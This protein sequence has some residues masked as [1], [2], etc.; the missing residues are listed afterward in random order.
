MHLDDKCII[1]NV[2]TKGISKWNCPMC[3]KMA[4]EDLDEENPFCP[5]CDIPLLHYD[6]SSDQYRTDL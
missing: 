3:Q 4:H 5:L 6:P 2:Q 1:T